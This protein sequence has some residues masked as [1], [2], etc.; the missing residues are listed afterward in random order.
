MIE[1]SIAIVNRSNM[2][3]IG[4]DVT[5]LTKSS[6]MIGLQTT[7]IYSFK[8]NYFSLR[9]FWLHRYYRSMQHNAT[10]FD[11]VHHRD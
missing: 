3:R 11:R 10:E 4:A 2:N 8:M 9:E 1:N 6:L 7:N 5:F